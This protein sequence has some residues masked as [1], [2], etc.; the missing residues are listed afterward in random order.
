VRR[1]R[2]LFHRR[3]DGNDRAMSLAL[4]FVLTA[5]SLAAAAFAIAYGLARR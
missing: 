4:A 3:R 1:I 2:W 5:G